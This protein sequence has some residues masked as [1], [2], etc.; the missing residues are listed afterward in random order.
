MSCEQSLK[1]LFIQ[2]ELYKTKANSIKG[3]GWVTVGL[4]S[5]SQQFY[6]VNGNLADGPG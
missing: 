6:G 2:G 1:S 3:L 5:I 4:G